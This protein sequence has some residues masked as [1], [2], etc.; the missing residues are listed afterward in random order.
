MK[1]AWWHRRQLEML[2][3]QECSCHG[4]CLKEFDSLINDVLEI[5]VWLNEMDSCM[6]QFVIATLR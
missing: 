1:P 6:K 4:K 2:V 3:K 5:R